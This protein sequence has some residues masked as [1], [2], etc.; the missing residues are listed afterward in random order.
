MCEGGGGCSRGGGC[1]KGDGC[2]ST[3]A[4]GVVARGSSGGL[5]VRGERGGVMRSSGSRVERLF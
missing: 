5:G 2:N 4:E 1:S 3:R